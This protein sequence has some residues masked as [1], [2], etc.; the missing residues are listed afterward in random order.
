MDRSQ[1]MRS[2]R[3]TD[4]QPE[5]AVRRMVFELGYRYRLHR[6]DLPGRPDLAFIGLRKVI[7]VHGCFWHGHTCKR[8]ARRPKTNVDYWK[9]KIARNVA[10]DASNESKL[11]ASGWDVLTV[12]E[13]ELTKPEELRAKLRTFLA[14]SELP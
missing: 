1:I 11:T 3:S 5:L 4:T 10:R 2:V 14:T 8:G 12:W 9:E 6:K 7:F 13:C